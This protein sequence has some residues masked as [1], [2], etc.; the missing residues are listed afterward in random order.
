[1]AA[2]NET[3][4]AGSLARCCDNKS[5]SLMLGNEGEEEM[6]TWLCPGAPLAALSFSPPRHAISAE[7]TAPPLSQCLIL[8]IQVGMV[9][10]SSYEI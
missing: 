7:E 3:K 8:Y 4:Q 2:V 10:D 6:Q 5:S 9:Q 1:M